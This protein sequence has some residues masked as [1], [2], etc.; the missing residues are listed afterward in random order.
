MKVS[1]PDLDFTPKAV[2]ANRDAIRKARAAYQ[3][4]INALAGLQKA[5]EAMCKHPNKEKRYDPGY[6]GG[7]YSHSEC[8]G[9]GGHL[10]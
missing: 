3:G 9:C 8:P 6:A 5:N 2:R 1:L 10:P 4:A 7:G